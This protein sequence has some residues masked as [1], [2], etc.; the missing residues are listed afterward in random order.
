MEKKLKRKINK[1]EKEINLSR[2]KIYPA[3]PV[4]RHYRTGVKFLSSE[5]MCFLLFHRDR[6]DGKA[7]FTWT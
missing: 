5:T 1:T 7:Y 3:C 2:I 6:S 4:G